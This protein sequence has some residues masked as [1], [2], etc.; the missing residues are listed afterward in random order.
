M[1]K[2][3]DG[4]EASK[5]LRAQ[6]AKGV[7]EMQQKHR[8]TPGLAAV[9]VGD[10]PASA[11]YI[12]N[13]ERACAEVG[14]LSEVFRLEHDASE[15]QLLE[16]VASLNADPKYHGIL[17]QLPL[18]DAVDPLRAIESLDHMKDVD[19]IHPAN[20]GR[21][22]VGSPRFVPCT[23]AGVQQ[24]LLHNGYDPAGKHV[25][26]CGR[27]QIV[28]L[29]LALLLMQRREGANATVTVCHTGTEDLASITRQADILVAAM[30]RAGAI[31][32]DMVSPGTVIVDVGVNRVPDPQSKRGYRLAGDVDFEGV[33]E[34]VEAIS[35]VPGGVGPMTI[36]MLLVN[37][38][39]A[40]RYSIHGDHGHGDHRSL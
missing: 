34:K 16:T 25:V 3:L 15:G 32:A 17:V 20:L 18:P 36:A 28:G 22:V 12:R 21:L 39:A 37:T 24:L 26:I 10:D 4:V 7:L 9:L 14:I 38:L 8:V 40:A 19:G 35:P 27:S 33:S 29:P 6:V 11:V 31:T 1:V 13:K 30:G 5:S 23:P 2:L